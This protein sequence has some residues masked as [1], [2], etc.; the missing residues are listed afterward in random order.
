MVIRNAEVLEYVEP[1]K[2]MFPKGAYWDKLLSDENSD[3][4]S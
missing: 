4:C 1:L 2:K 3:V